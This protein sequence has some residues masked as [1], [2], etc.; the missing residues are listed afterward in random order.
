MKKLVDINNIVLKLEDYFKHW[1]INRRIKIYF[2]LV[3]TLLS[4]FLGE[5]P[6]FNLIFDMRQ[7]IQI[8]AILFVI[9]FGINSKFLY[10]FFLIIMVLSLILIISGQDIK[11][12]V[13]GDNAYILLLLS[14]FLRL[15]RI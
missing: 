8:I 13:F 12:E 10:F 11:A 4:F 5:L 3:L 6:Y 1:L 15:L 2:F 9:V 14:A 7:P